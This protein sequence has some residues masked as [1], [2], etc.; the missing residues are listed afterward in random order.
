[1]KPLIL[2][3]TALCF[4]TVE[5]NTLDTTRF[6]I[7][8]LFQNYSK[9]IRPIEDQTKPIAVNVDLDLI[10]LNDFDEVEGTISMVV[11]LYISWNDQNLI[12]NPSLYGNVS[13]LTFKQD[14]IWLPEMFLCNPADSLT[15]IGNGHHKVTVHANGSVTWQPSDL[16]KA[17]CTPNVYR[18]PFDQQTCQ[19]SLSSWGYYSQQVKITISSPTFYFNFFHQNI[20]WKVISSRTEVWSGTFDMGYFKL[21][22]ERRHLNFLVTVV[23]PIIMLAFVNP[24]VFL[25]PF[26][27]GERTSYS[28]TVLLAFTV[29]MTVVSDRM[30]ASSQPISYISYYLLSLV[31]ISVAIVT[32]NI[33]QIRIYSKH[34]DDEPV[35]KWVRKSYLFTRN[36]FRHREVKTNDQLKKSFGTEYHGIDIK[37]PQ[38]LDTDSQNQNGDVFYTSVLPL[39]QVTEKSPTENLPIIYEKQQE[40]ITWHMVAKMIDKM[41]FFLFFILTIAT[42]M[43][44]FISAGAH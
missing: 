40:V 2:L 16:L 26:N 7:Q 11:V 21:T 39:A 33:F 30:P 23:I 28:I 15:P 37:G 36:L 12:W 10:S 24:F 4:H 31:G 5:T 20:E 32:T 18:Y 8:D 1:M 14:K 17:T 27:S 43:S 22:I 3:L 13:Y 35:P 44:Y 34:D 42:T 38:L 29:Y 9:D 19:L 41:C 6:L 25:L